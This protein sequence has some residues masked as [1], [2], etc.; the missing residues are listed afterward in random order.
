M[1][2]V[3]I[4]TYNYDVTNLVT[5][6][7]N[8]LSKNNIHFEIIVI[9][10]SSTN[11]ALAQQSKIITK[12]KSVHFLELKEN[13]GRSKIRN[14]LAAK[15]SYNWLLFLDNDVII[16]SVSY[17]NNYI[18]AIN[19]D[20]D[21]IYGGLEYNHEHSQNLLRT[22][23][24]KKREAINY[25]KRILSQKSHF[26]FSNV[27]LQKTIFNSVKFDESITN[28][29]H[30]DTLFQY[31]SGLKNHRVL[32]IDNSVFHNGLESNTMY[33]SKIQESLKTLFDL[34]RNNKLPHDYTKIQLYNS[35]L[36]KYYLRTPFFYISNLFKRFIISNLKSEK[37]SLVLFDIFKLNYFC[38]L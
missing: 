3:L 21:I 8:Q 28:Y 9:D 20:V 19:N 35:L 11:K 7:H 2:S 4:P 29:G 32:H 31:Q 18:N 13:I 25:N 24:G 14:L 33:L 17:I 34:E 37:P 16:K 23:V 27:L 12:F 26:L 15:A 36:K 6:L 1:L 10:D 38:S 30:E 22:I 5:Q